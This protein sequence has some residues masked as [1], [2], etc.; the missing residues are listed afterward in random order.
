[1][2]VVV[3]V[4]KNE[5]VVMGLCDDEREIASRYS[6][7]CPFFIWNLRPRKRKGT[8]QGEMVAMQT[9]ASRRSARQTPDASPGRY[10]GR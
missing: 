3:V 4:S 8:T 7:L 10:V 5:A 1:M 9:D 6:G 2:N